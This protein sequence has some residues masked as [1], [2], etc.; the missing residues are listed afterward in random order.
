[1]DPDLIG[2]FVAPLE[3]RL[4]LDVDGVTATVAPV[5]YVVLRNL[6]YFRMSG[7]DRHLRDVAMIL[8][9]SGE[10]LRW[11]EFERWIEALSLQAELTAAQAFQV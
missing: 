7:S 8:R 10:K 4:M 11:A 6:E 9:V 3:R 5:E 1:M 2:L